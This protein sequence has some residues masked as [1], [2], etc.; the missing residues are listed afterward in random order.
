[1]DEIN[2]FRFFF[3]LTFV[4][5]LILGVAWVLKKTGAARGMMGAGGEKTLKIVEIL[6]LDGKRRLVSVKHGAKKHLLLIGG[7]NDVV[8]ESGDDEKN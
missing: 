7:M 1:M 4:V 2:Y 6:P 3:A 8:V 5:A